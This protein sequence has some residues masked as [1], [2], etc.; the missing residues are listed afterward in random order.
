LITLEKVLTANDVGSTGGHQAGIAVPKT[1][2]A[3]GFFPRLD[4]NALNPRM[5]IRFGDRASG[6][7]ID[8]TYVYYNGKLH[9]SSTRNE[10]RL[11]GMTRYLRDR[12]ALEGDILSFVRSDSDAYSLEFKSSSLPAIASMSSDDDIIVLSGRWKTIQ[13]G[14]IA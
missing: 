1:K 7:P 14:R 10:Y 8:L 3:M 4:P 6:T 12:G 5:L 11:T 2:E 13:T 9:G